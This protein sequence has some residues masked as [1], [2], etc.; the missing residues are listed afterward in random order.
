MHRENTSDEKNK[1]AARKQWQA[2]RLELM[3]HPA[4]GPT[5]FPGEDSNY[6]PS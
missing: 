4:A 1:Q 6:R 2:P 5:L 3:G